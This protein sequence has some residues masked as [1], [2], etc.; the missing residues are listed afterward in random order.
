MGRVKTIARRTFLIGSATVAGGLVV[1]WIAY[2]W[3]VANPL[4]PDLD[5]GESARTSREEPV[6]RRGDR[7]SLA[8]HRAVE[9]RRTRWP[10]LHGEAPPRDVELLGHERGLHG[11]RTLPEIGARITMSA[12]MTVDVAAI[13][14]R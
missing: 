1:G 9:V 12:S 8:E 10:R 7:E 14:A 11:V 3:P 2:K 6:V 4:L 5:E 13:I